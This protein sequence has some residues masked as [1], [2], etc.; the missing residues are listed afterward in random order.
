MN[1]RPHRN[2][3]TRRNKTT[4]YRRCGT[5]LTECV[6]VMSLAGFVMLFGSGLIVLSMRI[7]QRLGEVRR[8]SMPLQQLSARLRQDVIQLPADQLEVNDDGRLLSFPSLAVSP[9][10]PAGSRVEYSIARHVCDRQIKNAEGKLVSGEQFRV[11]RDTSMTWTFDEETSLLSLKLNKDATADS[12]G[13]QQSLFVNVGRVS[14]AAASEE[15][16]P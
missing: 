1:K 12:P 3:A 16:S 5:S 6:V 15:E 7:D 8:E 2:K 11:P 9:N 14:L 13:R 10:N 4:Q